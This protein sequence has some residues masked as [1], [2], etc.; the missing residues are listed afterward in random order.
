MDV[1][2]SPMKRI[3]AKKPLSSKPIVFCNSV[4]IVAMDIKITGNSAV[5]T[6]IPKLGV[7]SSSNVFCS[8]REAI[9]PVLLNDSG[10]NLFANFVNNGPAKITV[11]MAMIKP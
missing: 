5:K 10:T 11:G 3:P 1:P 2:A 7:S 4:I 6:L 8:P 9:F